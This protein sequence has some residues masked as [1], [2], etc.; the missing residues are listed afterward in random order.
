MVWGFLRRRIDSHRITYL[1][2]SFLIPKTD[3]DIRQLKLIF[4]S[5]KLSPF[6]LNIFLV[7]RA[8]R[9]GRRIKVARNALSVI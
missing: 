9:I 5:Q 3:F 7:L 1:L 4:I 2:I 8:L 6:L